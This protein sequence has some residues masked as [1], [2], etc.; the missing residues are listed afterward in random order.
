MCPCFH[1]M[2]YLCPPSRKEKSFFQI[3]VPVCAHWLVYESGAQ[4]RAV[5]W[6][7]LLHVYRT[8]IEP[9]LPCSLSAA[10]RAQRQLGLKRLPQSMNTNGIDL[11][12]HFLHGDLWTFIAK[13][14][15]RP[16]CVLNSLKWWKSSCTV[17]PTEALR[18]CRKLS[19]W[20][21]CHYGAPLWI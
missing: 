18:F 14:E 3:P 10:Q 20:V 5:N 11:Y 7:W 12:L 13:E 16:L 9:W 8:P 1:E 19:N 2:K 6:H 15:S 4:W 21:W 17:I